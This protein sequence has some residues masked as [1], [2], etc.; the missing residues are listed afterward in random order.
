MSLLAIAP[1][2][3]ALL[4]ALMDDHNRL[5]G[6][7]ADRPGSLR[8]GAILPGTLR[9]SGPSGSFFNLGPGGEGFLDAA[10]ARKDL[11]SGTRIPVQVRCEAFRNKLPG[12]ST[13]LSLPGRFCIHL[14]GE[15]GILL[16]RRA[17]AVPACNDIPLL[18]KEAGLAGGF[19]VRQ[20]AAGANARDILA[21]ATFL[22]RLG[23]SIMAGEPFA[24][25]TAPMRILTDMMPFPARI[26]CAVPEALPDAWL[27]GMAPGLLPRLT[28]ERDGEALLEFLG[29]CDTID[30]LLSPTIPIPGGTL[31]MEQ[32][33]AL[34]AV[35]INAGSAPKAAFCI[36]AAREIARQIRLRNLSGMIIMDSPRMGGRKD[37]QNI[38]DA[39]SA[40][41]ADDP[42]TFDVAGYSPLRLLEATRTRRT[43]S[44]AECLT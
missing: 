23:T 25:L 43:P 22:S 1:Y 6:L 32:T 41:T 27:S 26:A 39:L 20:Q 13:E 4:A 9:N 35:D 24:G 34:V 19:I 28:R 8:F 14:P 30:A 33:E 2:R 3:G 29:L 42:C 7:E 18:L 37:E 12:L 44:L 21:E 10:K 15:S 31:V 38:A 16:S 36:D 11:P 17:R 5:I 40:S